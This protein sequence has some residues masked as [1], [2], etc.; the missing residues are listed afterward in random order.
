[1]RRHTIVAMLAVGVPW[2]Y[3]PALI[4]GAPFELHNAHIY[5]RVQV[6]E[7]VSGWFILDTGGST[8]LDSAIAA[9][10]GRTSVGK[11]TGYGGGEAGVTV[12][13]VD[14]VP[15]ALVDAAARS[16]ATLPAQRVAVLD[17]SPVARGEGR[18]VA[19]ILGGSFLA[20]YAVVIDYDRRWVE[21]HR[22]GDFRGPAGWIAVPLRVQGDVISARA[23]VTLR[24][25]AAPI[26]GW[27]HIDSGGA[28]AVILN[29][30]F[31]SRHGLATP[32]TAVPDAMQSVGGGAPAQPGRVDAIQIGGVMVKDVAALFSQAGSGFFSS[33]DFDGSIGGGLL[34]RFS[35]I[36]F[37][38]AGKRMWLGQR[39]S[40]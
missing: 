1:M 34:T 28:H 8:T 25:G 12:R 22:R 16:V 9:S 3:Q 39:K 26:A 27:Y 17:L 29:T 36:A 24:A 18:P 32:A 7:S 40:N 2:A 4:G 6:A 19:G 23:A 21:V 5:V 33:G 37:D 35:A 31:V 38:Y 10:L 15:L 20:R 13:Y 11:K 14:G 30:P